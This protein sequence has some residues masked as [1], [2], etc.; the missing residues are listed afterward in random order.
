PPGGGRLVAAGPP[1]PPVPVLVV[2]ELVVVAAGVDIE[3][4]TEVLH[5]HRRALDVPHRV[6]VAPRAGPPQRAVGS[7]LLPQREVLRVALGRIDRHLLTVTA[8]QPV[9]RVA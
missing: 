8:T 4:V 1:G 7:R 3:A 9:E 2:G 6:A 5:R